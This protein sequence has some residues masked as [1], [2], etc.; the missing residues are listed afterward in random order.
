MHWVSSWIFLRKRL[1]HFH[2]IES[3]N[4]K[5]IVWTWN[6]QMNILWTT[7]HLL[8]TI[9][10]HYLFYELF[11][12]PISL[13]DKRFKVKSNINCFYISLSSWLSWVDRIYIFL[14]HSIVLMTDLMTFMSWSYLYFI[15]HSIVLMTDLMTFMSWSYL[16]FLLHSIVLMNDLMTFMSWSYLLLC[17]Y[18]IL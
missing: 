13:R 16:Y 5:D 12:D 11:K 2:Y 4:S 6:F 1:I 18:D 9:W 17:P 8:L 15:L 10:F 14:L 3:E 7:W